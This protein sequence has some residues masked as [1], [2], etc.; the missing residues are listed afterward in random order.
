VRAAYV[1]LIFGAIACRPPG[2]GKGDQGDTDAAVDATNLVDGSID[3]STAVCDKAFRL[4]G[5]STAS[6]VWLTGDFIEWGGD[7][8]HGAAVFALGAD[9]GWTGN[10]V[11]GAGPHQYK[12]IVS[13]TE[14]INDPTNP[15]QID[16]GFGGKNSLFTCTP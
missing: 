8:G 7:P 12:F 3:G 6:S 10:Y 14:W 2:Y 4:D 16:D 5:R 1:L 9:G 13:G 15:D 11:F